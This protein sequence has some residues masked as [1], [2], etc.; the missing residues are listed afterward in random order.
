MRVLNLELPEDLQ[1]EINGH[2]F[3]VNKSDADILNKC[4]EFQSKYADLKKGDIVGIK[5]AVNAF[6]A[7]IDE[8]LG[9]GAVLKISGGRPV[10]I[11]RA[12]AWLTA[13]CGE[14]ARAGDD[15]IS[16]KYE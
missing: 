10:N 8:I 6:I 2:I 5:D 9:E 11:S 1:L 3:S 4:A 12:I 13:V 15:Y 7:Y 14:I 16:E